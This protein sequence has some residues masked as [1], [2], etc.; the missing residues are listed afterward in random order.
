M[1]CYDRCQRGMSWKETG[2]G[3]DA[4][5]SLGLFNGLFIMC[6]V[7]QNAKCQRYDQL[8]TAKV[9]SCPIWIQAKGNEI[10]QGY[11]GFTGLRH[12]RL[13]CRWV[14][15]RE[16]QHRR[17]QM[18]SHGLPF[19]CPKQHTQAS[20]AGPGLEGLM[21]HFR[22]MK[23]TYTKCRQKQTLGQRNISENAHFITYSVGKGGRMAKTSCTHSHPRAPSVLP[24]SQEIEFQPTGL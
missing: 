12:P 3:L 4:V 10:S 19:L 15:R 7:G 18:D 11:R 16:P 9:S 14:S 17:R 22:K 21:C 8:V 1:K 20:T 24:P 2:V 6:F 5:S 13:G 23:S